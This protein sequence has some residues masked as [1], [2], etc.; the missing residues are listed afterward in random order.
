MERPHKRMRTG[1]ASLLSLWEN[2][3]TVVEKKQEARRLVEKNAQC[4]AAL[5]HR[6]WDNASAVCKRLY[7]MGTRLE[8]IL[9][10]AQSLA[11][12]ELRVLP[13]TDIDSLQ[14]E[15]R[16]ASTVLVGAKAEMADFVEGIPMRPFYPDVDETEEA[17]TVLYCDLERFARCSVVLDRYAEL[18]LDLCQDGAILDELSERIK[19]V[20]GLLLREL[21]M[22]DNL[23]LHSWKLK[24][25]LTR[26]SR[27]LDHCIDDCSRA[28]TVL[29]ELRCLV[30]GAAHDT[31]PS[32]PRHRCYICRDEHV[33]GL[34]YC[35]T[36][37]GTV[38]HGCAP[39]LVSYACLSGHVSAN[40]GEAIHLMQ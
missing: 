24:A 16:V 36:C 9:R 28:A 4:H 19:S 5:T 12:E 30:S 6:L 11:L 7:S 40:K 27:R 31:L 20:H 13:I 2:Y 14:D 26:K 1:S 32:L 3:W 18:H 10:S 21:R 8:E 38:C 29:V 23:C 25:A 35:D 17:L 22:A 33:L 37:S 15:Y 39:Q 34:T